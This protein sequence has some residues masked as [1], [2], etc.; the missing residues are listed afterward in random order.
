MRYA[1]E[2]D[3]LP[4]QPTNTR[5]AAGEADLAT[6]TGAASRDAGLVSLT[7]REREVLRLVAQGQRTVEVAAALRLS[8]LTVNVHL[9]AIYRKLGVRTRTAA[10]RVANEHHLV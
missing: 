6:T 7:G 8:P 2:Q 3:P 4:V 10:T 1:L 5:S 9:R